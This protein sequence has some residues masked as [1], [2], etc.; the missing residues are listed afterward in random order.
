V[1]ANACHSAWLEFVGWAD[2][3]DSFN[4]VEA[5]RERAVRRPWPKPTAA[6]WP[7]ALDQ[8]SSRRPDQTGAARVLRWCAPPPLVLGAQAGLDKPM[9]A[10]SSWPAVSTCAAASGWDCPAGIPFDLEMVP[11]DLRIGCSASTAAYCLLRPPHHAVSRLQLERVY[12]R[13]RFAYHSPH[14]NP[15]S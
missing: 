12:G 10:A 7:I 3:R 5:S 6:T 13:V 9:A 8:R 11:P 4:W 2:S 14:P 1:C 15:S